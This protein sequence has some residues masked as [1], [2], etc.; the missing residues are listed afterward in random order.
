M[1]TDTKKFYVEPAPLTHPKGARCF[2][3]ET[4]SSVPMALGCANAGSC[5]VVLFPPERIVRDRKRTLRAIQAKRQSA[6]N[7]KLY[8]IIFD[9]KMEMIL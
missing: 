1:K 2:K 6:L 4:T 3:T 7:N 9:F 8:L 5:V